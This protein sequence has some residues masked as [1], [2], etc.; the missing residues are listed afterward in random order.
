[1]IMLSNTGWKS[2]LKE[3]IVQRLTGI[4]ITFYFLF[5]VFYL[6][7]NGGF[8]YLNWINLFSSFYFKIITVLFIFNIVLHLGIGMSIVTTDY[9]SSSMLRVFVDFLVNIFLLSYIFFI[10]QILW[11]FK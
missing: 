4:Y 5:I 8:T 2:G 3:W 10:M 11:G 7:L 1:M 9:I 6:F